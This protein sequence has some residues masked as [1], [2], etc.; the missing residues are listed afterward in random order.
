MF[1]AQ[2]DHT[3]HIENV[4]QRPPQLLRKLKEVGT[5]LDYYNAKFIVSPELFPL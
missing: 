1:N 4:V 5:Q 2:A 3:E